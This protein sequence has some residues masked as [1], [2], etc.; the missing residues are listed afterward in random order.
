MAANIFTGAISSD[1]SVAANWSLGAVPTNS[2]TNIVTFDNTSPNCTLSVSVGC[3]GIDFTGYVNILTLPPNKDL[4]VFGNTGSAST[5]T[6]ISTQSSVI[7]GTGALWLYDAIIPFTIIANGGTW[8][9]R[10]DIT[11]IAPVINITGTLTINGVFYIGGAGTTTINGGEII[12]NGGIIGYVAGTILT[13]TSP[14]TL[15]GGTLDAGASFLT[16]TSTNFRFNGNCTV[17][18]TLTFNT[19]TMTHISGEV[20]WTNTT[21]IIS[22]ANPS[23]TTATLNL[24]TMPTPLNNLTIGGGTITLLSDLYVRGTLYVAGSILNGSTLYIGANDLTRFFNLTVAG[25]G[26]NGT[27]LFTLNGTGTWSAISSS[28]V[29]RNNLTINTNGIITFGNIA[30]FGTRTLTYILGKVIIPKNSTFFM[31]VLG[32]TTLINCHKINFNTVTIVAGATIIMNEFFSGSPNK[33]VRVQSTSTNNYV[34]TF[35]NG[36]EKIAKYVKVSNLTL[37]NTAA[38]KGNLLILNNKGKYFRGSNNIGNIRYTNV[39]PNGIAKGE[40][41]VPNQMTA[42]IGGYLSDPVFN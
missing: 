3:C 39:S 5:I 18:G 12:F 32:A 29:I 25:T 19:G 35:Q 2:D 14:I 11:G 13:G 8:P 26:P 33:P 42:P 7:A 34:I 36:Y 16:I 31:P 20:D 22:S 30:S 9:N 4:I 27:T 24:G 23:T 37:T 10:L 40:P 21:L 28:S 41:T 6:F 17:T 15:G 38:S 1:W